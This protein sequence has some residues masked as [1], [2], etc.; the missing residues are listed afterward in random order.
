MWFKVDDKFWCHPKVIGLSSDALALWLKAGCWSAQQLTDGFVPKNA[1]PSL[2]TAEAAADLVASGLWEEIS[3][4]GFGFH[5]WEKFQPTRDQVE[6]DRKEAASRQRKSREARRRPDG[7]LGPVTDMSHRDTPVSHTS[8]SRPDPTR[9]TYGYVDP[10]SP[11][12]TRGREDG[13]DQFQSTFHQ[14]RID[15]DRV[16]AIW[17]ECF[18]ED[19]TDR[20][21]VALFQ[22]LQGKARAPIVDGT[23]YIVGALKQQPGECQNLLM[24]GAA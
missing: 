4:D 11:V 23:A 7:T 24:R 2:G 6:A 19:I 16:R 3:D 5:D 14:H 20:E 12:S 22:Q 15:P 17:S 13:T 18:R 21:I 8:P 1:I 9:P 10:S